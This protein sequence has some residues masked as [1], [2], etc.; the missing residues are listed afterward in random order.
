MNSI[1]L[2]AEIS[3]DPE[4]R[5]TTDNLAITTLWVTYPSARADDP[6]SKV[7]V[8]VFG[9]LAQVVSETLH[10]GE[11]VTIEGQLHMNSVKRED[12]RSEKH[13]EINAR[14]IYP[15]QHTLPQSLRVSGDSSGSAD[16][17]SD[18]GQEETPAPKP[19]AS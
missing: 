13:A 3:T 18:S 10:A 15:L 19:A 11:V 2:M 8:A 1:V 12:G 5:F 6:P 16:D 4:M 7:K 14:R 17:A 9:E